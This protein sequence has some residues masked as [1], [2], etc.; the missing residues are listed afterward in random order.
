M[1]YVRDEIR[2]LIEA[3]EKAERDEIS[4]LHHARKE[5]LQE[6]FRLAAL[7]MASA[8]LGREQIAQA[9]GVTDQQLD[10]WFC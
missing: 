8:G 9:L 10:A 4:R 1:A 6:G 7:G 3:R 2:E 5:G